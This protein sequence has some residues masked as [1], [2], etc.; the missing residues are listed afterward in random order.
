MSSYE[1]SIDNYINDEYS[2]CREERQYALYLSNILRY[3]G[4]NERIKALEGDLKTFLVKIYYLCGLI[5]DSKEIPDKLVIKD[6]FYEATFMSVQAT[7]PAPEHVDEP[8]PEP[9]AEPVA[10]TAAA[11]PDAETA[12]D[13]LPEQD[14]DAY[15]FMKLLMVKINR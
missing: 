13:A 2:I 8:A 9:A 3:Y 14:Y 6:V 11:E 4:K 1:L 7:E 15:I 12:T 10:E 5:K